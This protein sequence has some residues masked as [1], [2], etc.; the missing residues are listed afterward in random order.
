MLVDRRR[1][2]LGYYDEVGAVVTDGPVLRDGVG[3]ARRRRPGPAQARQGRPGL[4]RVTMTVKNGTADGGA[5]LAA[6]VA[7]RLA[8]ACA[9]P[10]L[11]AVWIRSRPLT[12]AATRD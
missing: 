9:V 11:Y 10:T 4:P 3:R 8:A 5:R 6:T 1:G 7:A 2:A 12:W